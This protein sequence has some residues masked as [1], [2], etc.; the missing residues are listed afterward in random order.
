MRSLFGFR[1]RT[2]KTPLAYRASERF[3]RD[4]VLPV[5]IRFSS[6]LDPARLTSLARAGVEWENG[7][8]PLASGAYAAKITEPH[9][10]LLSAEPT[11]VRVTCDLPRNAPRPLELS[12][13]ET[14]IDSARRMLRA[15]D[16]KL[17]DG[18]GTRIA[19]IDSGVFVFHPAF[20]RAD[21]GTYAWVDVDGDG[22]LTPGVD[23]VDL[24][25]S[26]TIEPTEVLRELKADKAD[27]KTGFDASLDW[28]YVDENG[29]GQRDFGKGFNELTP[30]YGEP[31]FVVDDVDQDG[32]IGRSEKLLR[33]GTSKVALARAN[34]T[35]TRGAETNGVISYGTALVGSAEKL[36]ASSHGTGVAGILVG[37]VPDR[38][39]L[40]GLAPGADLLAV[41]YGDRDPLGTAASIQWAITNKADVILTE[42]APYTGFPLDGSTEEEALLDAA[43]DKGIGV[44]TPAG[45]LSRGYKHR[46]VK[47]AVGAN[48][49]PL[50]TDSQFK[51]APYVAFTVLHRDAG[52]GV[53]LGVK[54]ALPDG[55]SIDVP[56]ESTGTPVD[57]PGGR[58]LDVV[59]RDSARGT[60]EIHVSLYAYDGTTW[61]KLPPGKWTLSITSS[62]AVDAE[63]FCA[64]GYNSWAYGLVFTSNTASKTICHPATHDKG[65]AIAAYTLHGDDPFGGGTPGALASYSS[66]GP[67]IDGAAGIDLAAPDNPM[68]TGVIDGPSS[69]AI[70]YDQFGGTS[71]AGPHV[72]AALALL[73]QNDPTLAGAALQDAL[74]SKARRDSFVTSD[75]TRWGKG[76]LDVAAALGIARNA[77]AP[78]TVK[79]VAPAEARIGTTV[80]LA[81]SVDDDGPAPRAQW[82]LDYDGKPDTAW[83][84]VGSQTITSEVP[85]VKT[86]RVDVLDADGFVRGA[87]ARIIFNETAPL[88]PTPATEVSSSD[89]GCGCSTPGSSSSS[90]GDRATP[91]AL[92]L[93]MLLLARRSRAR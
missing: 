12:A 74:L 61:G 65:I 25:G 80:S 48:D 79:L 67:R 31:I 23:G 66:M 92:G 63:L 71:G 49:I 34:K 4:G 51:S 14:G 16:G 5:V 70:R 68:S 24:D 58:L 88:A 83:L 37:G 39:K 64:D 36:E 27:R 40:L 21:A 20:F 42:Y 62:A 7:G 15:K 50:Q 53:T 82:D 85:A 43:V 76:K 93:A 13:T 19:A 11:L 46:S 45:N 84:P 60:H 52:L 35:Y 17:L 32:E 73:K 18:T 29:N 6:P 54:L 9:L 59:R 8:A 41:G 44:V 77:G 33:L 56:T 30:A 90:G 86:V 28:V 87:T 3:E 75:A 72:A 91:Y 47:L 69:T 2:G 57:I 81:V 38:T 1:A 55:T 78:P 10:A 89:D 22:K 26:G